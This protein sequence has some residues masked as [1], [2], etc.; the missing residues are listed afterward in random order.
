M[1]VIVYPDPAA[2]SA[3]TVARLCLALADAGAQREHVHLAIAGGSVGSQILGAVA[4]CDLAGHVNW[5]SVHVWWVDERFVPA[6]HPERND[7]ALADVFAAL[8]IPAANIHRMPSSDDASDPEQGARRYAAELAAFA[9]Q[10]LPMPVLDV[11]LLGMGPDGHVASLF[12]GH[13]ALAVDAEGTPARV[14]LAVMDSPKPPAQRISL[15]L[16]AVNHT[17]R[18]WVAAWGAEK[19]P[20]LAR[21]V[22]GAPAA[23]IPAAGVRGREE[24]LWLTD[25]AGAGEL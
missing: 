12:P 10:G 23:E 16:A 25:L 22:G 20:A 8:P 18:L 21:A 7:A 5:Q 4:A 13:G 6:D 19:A 3:V 15:S 9:T 24:T 17:R 11:V 2:L 1:T 14:A